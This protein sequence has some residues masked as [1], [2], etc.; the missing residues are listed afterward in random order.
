M[1]FIIKSIT[2]LETYPVRHPVLRAGQNLASCIM[3]ADDLPDTYHF[4]IYRDEKLV[5]VATFM[6][7]AT[8]HFDGKQYRLRGM[9]VLPEHRTLGLGRKLLSHGEQF[10]K[11]M[12][13]DTLWFNARVGALPFYKKMGYQAIGTPFE[14]EPIGTH[15]LMH[16][17]FK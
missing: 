14:I 13:V 2:A 7:D 16:K 9:A 8:S 3:E 11:N 12:N 15:Y 6:A 4:G 17:K 1:T 5:G 10:I